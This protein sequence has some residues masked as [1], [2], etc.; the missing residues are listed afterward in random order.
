MTEMLS[1]LQL[2]WGGSVGD[3]NMHR[4]LRMNRMNENNIQFDN[5]NNNAANNP[6]QQLIHARD[7]VLNHHMQQQK[8][9]LHKIERARINAASTKMVPTTDMI[10]L[11][12][13]S[14]E[15]LS[16]RGSN[17]YGNS[18]IVN[19]KS[20][21][22]LTDNNH[23]SRINNPFLN[24]VRKVSF[25]LGGL[26]NDN[27]AT[28]NETGVTGKYKD[29]STNN[30]SQ[31]PQISSPTPLSSS[32]IVSTSRISN[33]RNSNNNNS[34]KVMVSSQLSNKVG[35]QTISEQYKSTG[36]T[37]IQGTKPNNPKWV[38]Q[39][40]FFVLERFENMDLHFFCVLDGHGEV[41]HLVSRRCREVFKQYIKTSN[42][43]M[44]KAFSMMQN[45]LLEADFD[46]RCSG[47]TCVMIMYDGKGKLLSFNCG[48]SRAVIA[49]RIG[50]GKYMAIPLSN[51]HKPDMP[52]ERR[53]ILNCGGHVGCR[54]VLV[55]NGPRGPITKPAGPYRIWYQH[56]GD[57]LGLAMSRSMGDTVAHTV[58]VSAEPEILEH[59]VIADVDD[60][61]ILATDGVWDVID[62][63]SA[64]SIVQSYISKMGG[65]GRNWSSLEA[66]NWICKVARGRWEKVSPTVDDI[67]ALVVKL[68]DIPSR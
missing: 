20:L 42:V 68:K 55:S 60:F 66:S 23:T 19:K 9:Y 12:D 16:P 32:A 14:N 36:A 35:P 65:N 4:G 56:E 62:N 29:H 64:V 5:S 39:D 8:N 15:R 51:D 25:N 17:V 1:S 10:G 59:T 27:S 50:S 33:K 37:S 18:M 43:D 63:N 52:E 58:G 48:D 38:N 40:N 57:T 34:R 44:K 3:K 30:S 21:R 6:M 61:I 54:Q 53:R 24:G 13:G 49:R 46:T 28:T 45:D 2:S 67:T 31:L 41:G 47:A 22:K 7:R 26:G 11:H